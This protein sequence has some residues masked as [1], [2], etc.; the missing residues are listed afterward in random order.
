M[1]RRLAARLLREP[2]ERLGDDRDG[3][4]ERAARALFGL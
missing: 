4:H 3:S 1:S 2:L